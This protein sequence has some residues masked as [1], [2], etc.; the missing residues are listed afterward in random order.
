MNFEINY[1]NFPQVVGSNSGHQA[2]PWVYWHDPHRVQKN[3]SWC[4]HVRKWQGELS[5][6]LKPSTSSF[7][8][9]ILL[10]NNLPKYQCK[11]NFPLLCI[12]ISTNLKLGSVAGPV[13]LANGR[14]SQTFCWHGWDDNVCLEFRNTCSLGAWPNSLD[15]R[16]LWYCIVSPMLQT[17]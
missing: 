15:W 9:I 4:I 13:I 5:S 10:Y 1:A 8:M 14:Y 7:R 11:G 3:Q 12:S 17:K 6:C 2:S 16:P